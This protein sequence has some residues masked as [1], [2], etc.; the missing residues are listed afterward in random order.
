MEEEEEKEE[1]EKWLPYCAF[2]APKL[3]FLL[4]SRSFSSQY[5]FSDRSEVTEY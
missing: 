1:K 4:I 5:D 3:Y 2:K